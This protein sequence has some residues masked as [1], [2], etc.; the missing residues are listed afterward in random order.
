MNIP[1]TS[2]KFRNGKREE[3][4]NILIII[5]PNKAYGIDEIPRRFLKD[6]AELLTETLCKIINLFLGSK[7]P[8]MGK[9]TKVK[10]F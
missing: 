6:G 9:T 4:Y 5:D 2:F 10:P 8:V 1:S 7:F 3:V